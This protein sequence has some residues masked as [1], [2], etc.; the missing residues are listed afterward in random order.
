MLGK[1]KAKL[2][3]AG[4]RNVGYTATNAGE[5]PFPENYFDVVYLVTVLGEL[6]KPSKFLWEAHRVLKESGTLSISEHRP[7]PD[8]S[9]LA[10]VKSLVETEG[11]ELVC[12]HGPNWSYTAN[13]RKVVANLNAESVG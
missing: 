4:L 8:F 1:A 3:A 9:P 11:F 12:Q 10:E 13:F 2:E 6:D 5:I 7:D